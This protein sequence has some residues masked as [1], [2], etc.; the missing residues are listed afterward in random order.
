MNMPAST[1]RNTWIREGVW[2][3]LGQGFSALGTLLGVRA[4]TEFAPP[5][6]YG[7]VTLLLGFSML[8]SGT[9][10][11]P[12]IQAGMRLYPEY[13][14]GRV[15]QL[16]KALFLMLMR[17]T[18][19]GLVLIVFLWPLVS[20]FKPIPW[21]IYSL[22]VLLF[23]LEGLRS[24]ETALLNAARQQ[25]A[26]AFMA[27]S[28]AWLRPVLAIL[29]ILY[30]QA[31]ELG[32]FVGYAVSTSLILIVYYIWSN[33]KGKTICFSSHP[34]PPDNSSVENNKLQIRIR[35]YAFP[36]IPLAVMGTVSGIGDRYI[37]GGLLGVDMAGIYAAAY[38]LVSRPFL[39]LAGAVEMTVRPIY[40]HH[41]ARG[42]HT[43]AWSLLW[44]WLA[45]MLGVC[46]LALGFIYLMRD[47]LTA[48]LLAK[49]YAKSSELLP[50][51]AGGYCFLVLSH[52][53]EKVCYA[54]GDTWLI[55]VIQT[56]GAIIGLL[57]AWQG[58]RLFGLIG[59]AM[60]VPVYFGMQMLIAMFAA[61]VSWNHAKTR[62]PPEA[63]F[64]VIA[65]S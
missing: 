58:I 14:D 26:C 65:N 20:Y 13:V 19:A 17:R 39:M 3:S 55:L 47:E 9:L 32:I 2:V 34:L 5:E 22:L 25:S 21:L 37:I 6:V 11:T 38:G 8:I 62:M 40:N 50:W 56:V 30:I 54:Y 64:P 10:Y 49:D 46:T 43:K 48:I 27:V 57:V 12:I 59:A 7:S 24:V 52:V 28:E 63:E 45:T 35:D 53:F 51:I 4:L 41:I 16:R 42:Q 15:T 23:M 18:L 33:K 61:R 60:A 44:R 1:K 29:A 36:L 31:G